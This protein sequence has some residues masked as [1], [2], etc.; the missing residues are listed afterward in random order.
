MG[1]M[2]SSGLKGQRDNSPGQRPG[3]GDRVIVA[4]KGQKPWTEAMPP[5]YSFAPMGRSCALMPTQGAALG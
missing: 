3:Y 5:T 2:R 4:L 1:T